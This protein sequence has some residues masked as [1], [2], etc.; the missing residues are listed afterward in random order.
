MM[1]YIQVEGRTLHRLLGGWGTAHLL[2]PRDLGKS[3]EEHRATRAERG[4]AGLRTMGL[5]PGETGAASRG[6]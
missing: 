4:Q 2:C 1:V 6:L 3:E 5:V